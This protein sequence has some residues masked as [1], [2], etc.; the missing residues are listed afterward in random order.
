MQQLLKMETMWLLFVLPPTK[1]QRLRLFLALSQL[2]SKVMRQISK[3]WV[4]IKKDAIV[5]RHSARFKSDL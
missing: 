5:K 3:A 4:W 1:L 2:K